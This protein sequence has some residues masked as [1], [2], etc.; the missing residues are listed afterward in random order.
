VNIIHDFIPEGRKNRP[1]YKIIGPEYITIHS[2]GN[3]NKGANAAAHGSY[4]RGAAANVPASWHYTVDDKEIRQHLPL[5][6]V[7]WH[8]GDGSNGPGNRKSIAMEICENIDGD[9]SKAIDNAALLTAHLLQQFNLGLDKIKQH[10]DWSGKNCPR[11]FRNNPGS[12]DGFLLKV[13]GCLKPEA[14]TP[15]MGA[16]VASKDQARSWLQKK[17]PDWINMADLYYAIAPKYGIRADVALA[18][19]AKE[20]GYFRYGGL[21]QPWQNNFAGI[22]ATGQASDG[23][24]PLNGADPDRVRFEKGIHGAIFTDKATGVEAHIQHLYAYTTKDPLP[25]GTV[26]VDPRFILVQRGTAPYVEYL[27]AAENPAGVGWA[28]PGHDYGKSIM[29]DYLKDLLAIKAPIEVLPQPPAED[30]TK[31]EERIER[32]EKVLDQIREALK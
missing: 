26:L 21:V 11:I 2:T 25:E 27:G 19:A 6:E 22:G 8:A 29:R 3:T 15:I 31:L 16:A 17:A 5:N 20:T 4:L 24:T 32:L 13:E 9:L 30:L 10:Y 1:G 23:N 14:L 7:G 18:Q 12:W 28:Y